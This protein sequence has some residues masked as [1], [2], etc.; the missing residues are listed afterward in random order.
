[1]TT[2][3]DPRGHSK[4][5][6]S[7]DKA[8]RMLQNGKPDKTFSGKLPFRTQPEVHERIYLAAKQSGMSINA[9]MEAATD[10]AAREQLEQGSDRKVADPSQLLQRLL[11]GQTST[12]FDLVDQFKSQLKS[13]KTSASFEFIGAIELLLVGWDTVRPYL[14]VEKI[15]T[16]SDLVQSV[17]PLLNHQNPEDAL[18]FFDAIGKLAIGLAAIRACLKTDDAGVTLKIAEDVISALQVQ[19]ADDTG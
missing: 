15:S 19:G 8:F 13:Q 10:K 7:E 2:Q 6:A 14:D 4:G 12:M 18:E 5:N 9:W 17:I 16:I 11:D 3:L 1:M